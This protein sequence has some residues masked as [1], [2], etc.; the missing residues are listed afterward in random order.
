MAVKLAVQ[1][2][3]SALDHVTGPMANMERN[4]ARYSRSM[5]RHGAAIGASFGRLRGFVIGAAAALTTGLAAK[6]VKDFADH[7]DEVA[8]MSNIL[9]LTATAWQEMTYAA[10]MADLTSE[11]LAGAMK[12]M[13][14][15]KI[16]RAH[17]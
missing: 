14:N 1:T 16:G 3:F 8:R 10:K 11:D 4:G 6:A 5:Q 13:N 2:I 12:K 9:G 7:S 17:V 15:N